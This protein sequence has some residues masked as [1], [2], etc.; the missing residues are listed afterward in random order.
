MCM[1]LGG[2]IREGSFLLLKSWRLSLADT[3]PDAVGAGAVLQRSHL[4]PRDVRRRD[5][6]PAVHLR[7]RPAVIP[8]AHHRC[9]SSSLPDLNE[10][11][12]ML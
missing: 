6:L 10:M 9:G 3:F 1:I 7:P 8:A 4:Q 12:D 2:R 11:P 5:H